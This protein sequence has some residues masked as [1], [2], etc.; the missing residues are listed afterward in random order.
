MRDKK[1]GYYLFFTNSW[2]T[3]L[4]LVAFAFVNWD[5]WITEYNLKHFPKD[6]KLSFLIRDVSDKNLWV[7]EENGIDEYSI[8]DGY[9]ANKIKEKRIDFM[10]EQSEYSWA[11][12]NY[13]DY[14]NDKRLT[15]DGRRSN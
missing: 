4:V 7:L 6:E 15:A 8:E 14:L 9:L 11:S 3:Y 5:V 10:N 1:T 2:A 13:A 12:W